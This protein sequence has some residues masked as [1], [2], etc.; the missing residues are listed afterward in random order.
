MRE[1]TRRAPP[2]RLV[3]SCAYYF[4]ASATLAIAELVLFTTNLVPRAF[5]IFYGKGPGDE[6][7]SLRPRYLKVYHRLSPGVELGWAPLGPVPL[8]WA[9]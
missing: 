2:E 9:R 8:G 3:L 1:R 5:P 6:L 4:Q 7:G